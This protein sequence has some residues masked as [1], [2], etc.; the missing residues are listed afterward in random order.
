ME[1]RLGGG[2]SPENGEHE[3]ADALRVEI[4]IAG[5]TDTV[6]SAADNDRLSRERAEAVEAA[7]R[8]TFAARGVMS[9]AVAAVGRGE[10]ELLVETADQVS[11]PKNRRVEITVR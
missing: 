11:E 7:L 3:E 1:A 6:G 5:H 8:E 9:D 10:R 2:A 4:V